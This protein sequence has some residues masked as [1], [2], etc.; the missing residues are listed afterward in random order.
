M[1]AF[2]FRNVN[3]YDKASMHQPGEHAI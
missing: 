2:L 3:V 1:I